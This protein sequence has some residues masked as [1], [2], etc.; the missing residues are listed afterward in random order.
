MGRADS[1]PVSDEAGLVAVQ[2]RLVDVAPEI[3][4]VTGDVALRETAERTVATALGAFGQ[5]DVLFNNA[6][7]MTSGDFRE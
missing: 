7:V 3:V 1:E 2:R 5:V 6:G 4:A